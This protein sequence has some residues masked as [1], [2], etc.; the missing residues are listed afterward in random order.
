MAKRQTEGDG[1]SYIPPE[2]DDENEEIVSRAPEEQRIRVYKEKRKKGKVVTVVG[3]LVL[4]MPDM[5]D[6]ARALRNA[7]GIG[8]TAREE[9]VELQGD[10]QDRARAWLEKNGWGLR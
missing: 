6:L 3:N 8:G 4:A 2:M 5:K 1:W 10:C 9:F 7:L